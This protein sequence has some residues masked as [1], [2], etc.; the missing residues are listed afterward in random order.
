MPSFAEGPRVLRKEDRASRGATI[1]VIEAGDGES[2][3]RIAH[4]KGG[5]GWWPETALEAQPA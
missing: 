3:Y 5:E 1:M 4:D 2:V